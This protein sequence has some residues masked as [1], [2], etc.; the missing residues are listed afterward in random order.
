MLAKG[1]FSN[2]KEAAKEGILDQW[3]EKE[4]NVSQELCARAINHPPRE[5][6]KPECSV[7]ETKNIPPSVI[8]A[9][10]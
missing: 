6:C 8:G 3:E 4:S 5:L 2:R 9:H 10:C 1:S 7:T